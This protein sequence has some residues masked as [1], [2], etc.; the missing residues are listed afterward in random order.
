MSKQLKPTQW[1][2]LFRL[3]ESSGT[4]TVWIEY[5]KY[6]KLTYSSKVWFIVKYKKVFKSQ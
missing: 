5:A 2:K 4:P 3:Y 6:K 1:I